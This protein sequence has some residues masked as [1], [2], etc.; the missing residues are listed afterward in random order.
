M[1]FP[2]VPRFFREG[3]RMLFS[4]KISNISSGDLNGTAELQFL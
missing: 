4:T 2:N 1:V 3:D